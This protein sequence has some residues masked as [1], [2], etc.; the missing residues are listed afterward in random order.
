M[1]H[2]G[3]AAVEPDV[4]QAETRVLREQVS[5]LSDH[6]VQLTSHNRR[7]HDDLIATEATYHGRVTDL[8][9]TL[10]DALSRIRSLEARNAILEEREKRRRS[11]LGN[12]R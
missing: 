11:S 6:T 1:S 9:S 12:S 8:S 2:V 4:A 5:L 10:S 3:V 7:L